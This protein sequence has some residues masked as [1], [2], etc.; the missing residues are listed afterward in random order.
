MKYNPYLSKQKFQTFYTS[1]KELMLIDGTEYIG[2]YHLYFNNKYTD[3][4]HSETSYKLIPYTNDKNVINYINI[5]KLNTLSFKEPLP[6]IPNDFTKD[7]FER[8]FI[9]KRNE[10]KIIE[11]DEKQFSNRTLN[12]N[13]YQTI[14]LNWMIRGNINTTKK[15]N[16]IIQYGISDINKKT[17]YENDK[18]MNGLKD[19]L[20]NYLQ[21][22]QET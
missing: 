16:G 7:S 17:V 11:V 9:K 8:Y 12:K 4:L 3:K 19:Y 15:S 14:S 1:G 22:Y 6:F 13:L 21:F 2:Y 18:I 5:K 10:N 20:T